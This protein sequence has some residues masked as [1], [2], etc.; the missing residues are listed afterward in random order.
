MMEIILK[1]INEAGGI[2]AAAIASR[3]GLLI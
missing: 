1:K 3:D 2:E